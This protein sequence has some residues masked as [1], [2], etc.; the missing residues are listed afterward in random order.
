MISLSELRRSQR[1][2]LKLR[3]RLL[4]EIMPTMRHQTTFKLELMSLKITSRINF[5]FPKLFAK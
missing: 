4:I 5:R 3:K 1:L 2:T